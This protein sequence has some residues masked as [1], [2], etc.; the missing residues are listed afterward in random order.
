[1]VW[2]PPL[3]AMLATWTQICLCWAAGTSLGGRGEQQQ[4]RQ[5]RMTGYPGCMHLMLLAG[6]HSN[7]VPESVC[8]LQ[9]CILR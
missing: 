7:N 4:Q 8:I 9:A 2:V 3:W 5:K 1:M 6:V